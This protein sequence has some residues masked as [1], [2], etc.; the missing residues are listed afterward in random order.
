MY[1]MVCF[2]DIGI[3]FLLISFFLLVYMFYSFIKF[4]VSLHLRHMIVCVKHCVRRVFN[5]CVF[6]M[7]PLCQSFSEKTVSMGRSS[8]WSFIVLHCSHENMHTPSRQK[9]IF[10][11]NGKE[12][13]CKNAECLVGEDPARFSGKS[14]LEKVTRYLNLGFVLTWAWLS[15]RT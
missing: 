15:A 13:S 1:F 4:L 14:V 12:F 3:C 8:L 11:L 5:T 7:I 6:I 10:E 2:L 9:A